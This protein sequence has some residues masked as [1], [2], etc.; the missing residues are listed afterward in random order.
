MGMGF[1]Y[2]DLMG[3]LMMLRPIINNVNVVERK[4]MMI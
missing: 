2:H 3:E 4:I 1:I